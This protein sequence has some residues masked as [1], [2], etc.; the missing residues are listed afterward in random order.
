MASSLQVKQALNMGMLYWSFISHRLSFI[1]GVTVKSVCETY[2]LL[3]SGSAPRTTTGANT[4]SSYQLHNIER[5]RDVWVTNC[6]GCGRKRSWP[7]WGALTALVRDTRRIS[8]A[9]DCHKD[10]VQCGTSR[11]QSKEWC[12][13]NRDV[14]WNYQPDTRVIH[15]QFIWHVYF[16]TF[17][18]LNYSINL[19]PRVYCLYR[20]Q[21]S[22]G[23]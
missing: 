8:V 10:Y 6:G 5:C 23:K 16:V 20:K 18:E 15:C 2:V 11:T 22:G 3:T 4:A 13:L 14:Q 19:S 7:V 21:N 9:I 1:W 17:C 12:Y